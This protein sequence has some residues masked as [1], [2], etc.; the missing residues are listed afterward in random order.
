[1]PNRLVTAIILVGAALAAAWPTFAPARPPEADPAA[2]ELFEKKVRPVLVE[3]CYSCHSAAAITAK[4]LKGSLLLDTRDGLLKGGDTG[5]A[6][7]PGKPGDSLL[8][9]A[10]RH[11][12]DLKMPPKGK[13]PDAA[14]AD[15]ERWIALGAPDPRTASV[16]GPSGRTIGGRDFWAYRPVAKPA[17]PAVRDAAWPANDID[18]F[19][20][21]RLETAGLRPAVDADRATLARRLY[22]DL[23]GLP[24]T[25]EQVDTYFADSRPDAY[26]R[27][28]DSLLASPA[29]GERWG[30]HW[31]DVARFAESV[32]LRGLVL[33][34][35]WRYRDYVIDAFDQDVPFD[36]FVREQ[37][38]GDLLPA[39]T[40]ADR[41]R[42]LIATGFLV[43]GNTNL[44]EQDKVQLRMDVVDEQLDVIGKGLFAQTVT[45][46]RCHDHKF[47]PIPTADYYALAGILRNAISLEDANVSKWIEVPLPGDPADEERLAAQ[48]AAVGAIQAQIKVE[49]AKRPVVAKTGPLPIKDVPGIVVDDTR[50]KKVGTWKESQ[51]T[52]TYI[53]VGYLHD[54][55]EGKGDKTLTFQPDLPASGRYE[56]RLAYSPGKGRSTAVPVTV[57]SADGDKTINVNMQRTPP[58]EGRYMSL[59]KFQFERNGQS[60]VIVSNE[61]TTGHVTADA[62]VFLPADAPPTPAGATDDPVTKLEAEM[63]HLQASGP[64]RSMTMSVVE[65]TKPTD[66]RVHVRGSVHTLGEIVPRGYLRV[67]TRGTPPVIP[68]GESGRRQLAEWIVS[69]DNPLT[70]RVFVNRAWHW[71]FGA[72]LVRT[73]DTFGTTGE[74]PSHPELLDHLATRFVED[75]WSMKSLVRRIVLSRTYRQSALANAAEKDPENRLLAHQNRR[76]LDAEC[77]RDTM[78]AIAG[79]LRR[80]RGGRT[81]RADLTADYGQRSDDGRRSVFVPAF[82]NSMSELLEAFDMADSS[83]TTGRRNVST[84]APQALVLLNQQFVI[85]QARLTARRLLSELPSDDDARVSRLYRQT[86]G[87][88]PTD[89]ERQAVLRHVH[90][91]ADTAEAWARVVQSL[92]ASV[93][94]RYVN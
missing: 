55:N 28:V 50:A 94:F 60:F 76:R 77:I 54:A 92:L 7:V 11:G 69:P 79:D 51:S 91:A 61:G 57:F 46:A 84:V 38:A 93:E 90:H 53:G 56:V 30:R 25:L 49:R 5:P 43:L 10:L 34:E 67:A 9:Q 32:T 45:C 78:L 63:K 35:A 86:L 58:V 24:P 3:H 62:V 64:K 44:E 74:L 27:L 14:I 85:E 89:A 29:F 68:A 59:G 41:R 73:T 22:F 72:G 17:V 2:L 83:V 87:R 21:A 70:A 37:V 42:Q 71:L 20:L 31:L 81:F 1:M 40:P 65:E 82:R 12:D 39:A 52:A 13:L 47:D 4:K 23:T 66:T 26:E 75:G 36:R 19:V 33:K 48:A 80:D 18:R 6:I 88:L 15:I 16:S 8:V